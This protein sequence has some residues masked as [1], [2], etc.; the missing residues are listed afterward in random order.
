MLGLGLVISELP[1]RWWLFLGRGVPGH[2]GQRQDR[3]GEET[4]GGWGG[5]GRGVCSDSRVRSLDLTQ[6]PVGTSGGDRKRSVFFFPS[7]FQ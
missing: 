7:F 2:G 4:R 5:G 6:R 1:D 3:S